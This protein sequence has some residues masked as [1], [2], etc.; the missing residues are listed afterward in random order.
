MHLVRPLE[1]VC[2]PPELETHRDA[3]AQKY[4]TISCGAPI[5]NEG[6]LSKR[7]LWA[8]FAISLASMALRFVARAPWL[9][10]PGFGLDDY[11]M[12][13]ALAALI[14]LEIAVEISE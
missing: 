5:R 6:P 12:L 9:N 3:A 1:E 10:G 11:T 13:V 4:Q 2:L 7:V 8:L 14:P